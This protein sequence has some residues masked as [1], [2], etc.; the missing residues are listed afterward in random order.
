MLGIDQKLRTLRRI[1]AVD[2][3]QTVE[4]R[5]QR[6]RRTARKVVLIAPL[7]ARQNIR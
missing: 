4:E 2:S 3:V 6:S 5:Y 7:I 1:L